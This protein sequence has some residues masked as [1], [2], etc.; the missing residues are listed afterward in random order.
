MCKLRGFPLALSV[1]VGPAKCFRLW[2][3]FRSLRMRSARPDRPELKQLQYTFPWTGNSKTFIF[4]LV[5]S[6]LSGW[7]SSWRKNPKRMKMKRVIWQLWLLGV[8]NHKIQPY[9]LPRLGWFSSLVFALYWRL[10]SLNSIQSMIQKQLKQPQPHKPPPI[11]VFNCAELDA[12]AL[13]KVGRNPSLH[14]TFMWWSSC[15]LIDASCR[16]WT[17]REWSHGWLSQAV[18]VHNFPFCA[19]KQGR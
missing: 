1:S 9:H 15:I 7:W 8:K 10:F 4:I 16:I 12:L 11:E 17:P 14:V 18:L 3:S 19:F 5:S 13:L 6:S 2:C